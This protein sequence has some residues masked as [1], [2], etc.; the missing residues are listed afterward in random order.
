MANTNE[1]VTETVTYDHI[2]ESVRAYVATCPYLAQFKRLLV[3]NLQD[4][5]GS[6]S[7]DTV[8]VDTVLE[9]YI[10]GSTKEQYVFT[11]AGRLAYS[12]EIANNIN[13]SGIFE[14]IQNWLDTQTKAG[15]LPA[16]PSGLT[17]TDI[18]AMSSGYVL[19]VAGD[20]SSARYQ[21][22]CR[23]IYERG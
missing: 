15:V 11:I 19:N 20:L 17:A 9:E 7:I 13:N 1:N 14:D 23:L 8:P 2:V 5:T 16:L 21:I 12:D 6:Y 3:D 10:D 4:K 18:E 22:Q